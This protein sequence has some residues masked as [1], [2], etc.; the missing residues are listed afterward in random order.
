MTIMPVYTQLLQRYQDMTAISCDPELI[1]ACKVIGY[2]YH[3]LWINCG[4][5]L[6]D[7]DIAVESYRKVA[8]FEKAKDFP[9]NIMDRNW[10]S[11]TR[12]FH[13]DPQRS[14]DEKIYAGL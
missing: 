8:Q 2:K 14:S 3:L 9:S 6:D 4:L 10:D 12:A 5:Q 13:L 1:F 11:M 7:R